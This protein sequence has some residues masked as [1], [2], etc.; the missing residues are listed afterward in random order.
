METK[1]GSSE[2]VK[3]PARGMVAIHLIFLSPIVSLILVLSL[4]QW[5]Q[6]LLFNARGQRELEF[7]FY[8]A[9]V[10]TLAN[11]AAIAVLVVGL[12]LF[13]SAGR[14]GRMDKIKGNRI[15]AILGWLL[16]LWGIIVTFGSLFG[17]E[18][19]LQWASDPLKRPLSIWEYLEYGTW[20]LKG[21]LW[22]VSGLL[23]ARA[24]VVRFLTYVHEILFHDNVPT[25]L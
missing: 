2:V 18:L 19:L 20:M 10:S 8:P 21:V 22:A 3:E 6:E 11:L 14:N 25:K 24:S 16:V 17:Y 13:V 23:L 5:T 15:I 9:I 7:L 1:T 4:I 12:G